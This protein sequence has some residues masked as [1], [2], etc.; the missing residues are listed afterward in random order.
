[1]NKKYFKISQFGQRLTI[2]TKLD[3]SNK[4]GQFGQNW[5]IRTKLDNFGQNYTFWTNNI[6][7]WILKEQKE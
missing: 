1:M 4:I 7:I 6:P 2:R 3:K 5:T